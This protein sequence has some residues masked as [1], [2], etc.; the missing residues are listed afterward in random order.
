MKV[1]LSKSN[2]CD[3][4]TYRQVRE[5][6]ETLDCEILE[7]TGGSYSNDDVLRSDMMVVIPPDY[8]SRIKHGDAKKVNIGRGQYD[9]IRDFFGRNHERVSESSVIF[10]PLSDKLVLLISHIE[11]SGSI[12]VEEVKGLKK[13]K[14][15]DWKLHWGDT[16]DYDMQI[17]ITNYIS[18]RKYA[19]RGLYKDK[20]TGVINLPSQAGK[21]DINLKPVPHLACRN[22]FK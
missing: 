20:S 12:Y 19:N 18:Q 22:L 6:L 1:Y 10:D 16:I 14:E 7:Y 3:Y 21:K 4:R 5:L 2:A 17:N 15:E 13:S 11:E 8:K 9:Q